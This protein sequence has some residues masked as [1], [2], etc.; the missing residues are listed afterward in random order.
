MPTPKTA[1]AMRGKPMSQ[2]MIET[3][4]K[5]IV[6]AMNILWVGTDLAGDSSKGRSFGELNFAFSRSACMQQNLYF[7][8]LPHGHFSFLFVMRVSCCRFGARHIGARF[9][10]L[11][12]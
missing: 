7:L 10:R 4:A 8:P 2:T 12:G 5:A 6:A 1:P 9:A 3:A 11:G